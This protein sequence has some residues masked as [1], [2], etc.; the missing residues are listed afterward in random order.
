[1]CVDTLKSS[2]YHPYTCIHL[3]VLIA[4]I[5]FACLFVCLFPMQICA[6]ARNALKC[7]APA[8]EVRWR[9]LTIWQDRRATT[10][11]VGEDRQAIFILGSETLFCFHVSPDSSP[12]LVASKRYRLVGEA[13]DVFL[14][15]NSLWRTALWQKIV[16]HLGHGAHFALRHMTQL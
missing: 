1:M 12:I 10:C 4:P 11:S 5:L 16:L 8:N 3:T 15:W 6:A 13:D 9:V 2:P 14:G 7:S